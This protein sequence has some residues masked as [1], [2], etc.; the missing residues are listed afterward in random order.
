[1]DGFSGD[2]KRERERERRPAANRSSRIVP[3]ST[4]VSAAVVVLL[5]IVFTAVLVRLSTSQSVDNRVSR[6]LE[7]RVMAPGNDAEDTSGGSVRAAMDSFQYA[8][9]W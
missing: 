4:K 5:A 6:E 2:A 9:K 8:G 7:G 3:L 1:M